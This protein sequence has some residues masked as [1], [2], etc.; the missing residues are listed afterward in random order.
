MET[1][2]K[3]LIEL[4]DYF[5]EEKTCYEFLAL[6]IWD[7]GKP[8]CPHC[9]STHV[10]TT[11]SRS[12]KPSRKDVPEYRCANKECGKKFSATVGTIFHASKISLR[13]W[14]AA[15]FLITTAKKGISS[16][17]LATQLNVTQ[18]T[19]WYLLH[20]IRAMLKETAPN[21]LK[22]IVEIDETYVGGKNKNRHLNKKTK[23]SQGRSSTDK[24]AVVGILERDGRVLT[25][26]VPSTDA[27]ILQPIMVDHVEKGSEL[28]TDSYSS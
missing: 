8:V 14:Y 2:F 21:M 15:I 23:N 9:N 12:S 19:A 3:S 5:K 6:Q 17:Q 4:N 7:K 16:L 13:T 22:G 26:V 20:R 25:F 27:S 11:K 10:Y 18:K 28:I 1:N 24:T